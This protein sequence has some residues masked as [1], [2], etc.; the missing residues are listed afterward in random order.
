MTGPLLYLTGEY[1]R[2]TDTFIQR[3]VAALRAQG[4]AVMT[5]SIR[6]T[7]PEHLVGEEQIAE[8]AQT[9]HVLEA[10]KHPLRLAAAKLRLL[11]HPGRFFRAFALVWRTAPGGLRNWL[12]QMFYFAEAIVLADHMQRHGVRHLHNHIAK[13]SCT[14]AM[15][16]SELSGI[17]YSFTLHGPDIFFAPDHWRLDEKIARARF[18]AC[19][20]EFC[21]AQAMIFSDRALW[22]KLHIVHCGIDPA[23]YDP[24]PR[25][26]PPHLTFVGR[27]AAV[28][29]VPVL[30]EAL[31]FLKGELPRLRVTLIGDGPERARLEQDAADLGLRDVVDF[32]GYRSQSE[33][34]RAL[35][36]T[37]ALVLPSFAEGVPVV[38]MEAMA[39]GRPVITTGV[40]GVSELVEHGKSGFLVPPGDAQ[41]L[42][43]A[44]RAVLADPD[45]RIEMGR[46]G[47]TR[48]VEDFDIGKE[49]AWL[50]RLFEVYADGAAHPGKRP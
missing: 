8:A 25:Q 37:D 41:R 34:A 15:L 38:L 1:P 43:Q 9:F 28:K 32:A 24:A 2:V 23:R 5:A 36:V 22:D 3:E 47:R 19:I 45:R 42:A 7:G 48:V 6:R 50:G 4:I 35:K 30:L 16:A 14:V 40:A 13:A 27:L 18:V 20:S 49:A 33:V 44:I 12:W 39:A 31:S 11:R 17:P 46:T 26:G 10:A 21:R 29:G